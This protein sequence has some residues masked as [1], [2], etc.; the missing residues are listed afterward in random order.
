MA[1]VLLAYGDAEAAYTEGKLLRVLSRL[2]KDGHEVSVVTCDVAYEK[3]AAKLGFPAVSYPF[4]HKNI[5]LKDRITVT[6]QMITECEGITLDD[7]PLWKVMALDDF[8]GS[9]MLWDAF[10]PAEATIDADVVLIPFMQV[11]N[12]TR[13]TS[14]LYGWVAQQARKK[15]I[16]LIGIEV[17]PIGNKNTLSHIPVDTWAVRSYYS[18]QFLCSQGKARPEHVYILRPDE[19]YLLRTGGEAFYEGCLQAEDEMRK[20]MQVPRDGPVFFIPHHVGFMYET[21]R[22]L[23]ELRNV[24]PPFTVVLRVDNKVMRRQYTEKEIAVR[25]YRSAMEKLPRVVLI[26]DGV[27]I[28]LLANFADVIISTFA[29]S[30]TDYGLTTRKP[31]IIYQAGCQQ[32]WNGDFFRWMDDAQ[33]IPPLLKQWQ[34]M[35][36]LRSWSLS[37]IVAATTQHPV[38]LTNGLDSQPAEKLNQLMKGIQLT[39]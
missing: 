15:G 29:G 30:I 27:G 5:E 22:I 2:K 7:L 13:P 39:L 9:I 24:P 4:P 37:D 12:N 23:E 36:L 17:S 8:V 33:E 1:K 16:P 14:G 10:P 34:Q 3:E 31:T 20:A 26:D 19:Q 28:G 38:R 25:T 6:K 18:K 11:D 21:R 35:G 32:R